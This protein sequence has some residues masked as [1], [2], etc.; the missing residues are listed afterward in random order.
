MCFLE[1][2]PSVT[3]SGEIS[4]F[5]DV[6]KQRLLELSPPPFI[7]KVFVLREFRHPS[8]KLVVRTKI[9]TSAN[10]VGSIPLHFVQS[11]DYARSG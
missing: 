9:Q 7:V 3:I 11:I 6:P 5:G 4:R 8:G 10:G 1:K 2:F